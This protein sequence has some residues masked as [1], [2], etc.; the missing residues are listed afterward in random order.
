MKLVPIHI[1]RFL[2]KCRHWMV[3]IWDHTKVA[4]SRPARK[5]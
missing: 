5:L 1:Y 2:I 3:N 4:L